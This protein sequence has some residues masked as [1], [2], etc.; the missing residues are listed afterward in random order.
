MLVAIQLGAYRHTIVGVFTTVDAAEK[1]SVDFLK[2]ERDDYHSVEVIN[3]ESGVEEHYC[4]YDRKDKLSPDPVVKKNR[5]TYTTPT[6]IV[7]TEI[8]RVVDKV[9]TLI[10]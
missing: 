6:K 4:L 7:K 10:G 1:A 2:K 5:H 3:M 9:R 8:F